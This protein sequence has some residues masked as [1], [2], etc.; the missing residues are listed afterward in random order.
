M[1]KFKKHISW[2]MKRFRQ[3]RIDSIS[4]HAAYFIIISFIPFVAVTI[5]LL[6]KI[7]ISGTALIVRGLEIF[8]DA[9]AEYIQA[10]MIENIPSTGVISVSI[11]VF[12]WAAS[13]GMVAII[14]G[15]HKVYR[16]KQNRNYVILKATSILYVIAF[17]IVL[18]LVAA[19]IIFGSSLYA[20]VLEKAPDAIVFLMQKL[21]SGFGYV[22]LILFFML[23]Y[24]AIP[25]RKGMFWGNLVGSL[26]TA[27]GWIIFSL[28]FAFFVDNFAN[29]SLIY[30]S[31][32]AFIILMFWLYS[33]MLIMFIGAEIAVWS[34]Y[35]GVKDDIK[36]GLSKIFGK[37]RKKEEEVLELAE[38]EDIEW[39][40]STSRMPEDSDDLSGKDTAETKDSLTEKKSHIEMLKTKKNAHNTDKS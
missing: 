22:L 26:F 9:V 1:Q 19:S 35:S 13:S 3:D 30:G 10:V 5:T 34:V 36:D 8:P 37:R 40:E 38:G 25:R 33:C 31:L 11:I 14:K 17:A 28:I 39:A 21:R 18:V 4:A 24:N 7:N 32:A 12:L 15:L 20:Y 6:A 23:M 2:F 27:T 29:F 16:V